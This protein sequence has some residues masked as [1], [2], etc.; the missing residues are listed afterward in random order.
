MILA[1]NAEINDKILC[2]LV[3][4]ERGFNDFEKKEGK[5]YLLIII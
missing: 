5:N 3:K 1:G 4:K 2:R